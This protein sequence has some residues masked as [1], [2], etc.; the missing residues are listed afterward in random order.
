[1]THDG[2]PDEKEL[3]QIKYWPYTDLFGLFDFIKERWAYS[4]WGW[5]E[6]WVKRKIGEKNEVL[7]L[8]ISTG[9]WSGNEDIIEALLA[10]QMVQ[11]LTYTSWRRGGHYEFEIS[12]E[13]MGYKPA[14]DWVKKLNISR[15]AVYRSGMKA[16]D[17]GNR[18]KLFKRND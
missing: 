15:Q 7:S 1:M 12:P 3:E 4:D 8:H 11:V 17:R 9:G 6:T 13:V 16:L 10:N 2:Y 5:K 14:K 18:I